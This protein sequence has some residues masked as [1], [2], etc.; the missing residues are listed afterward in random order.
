M[1]QV[2]FILTCLFIA[3]LM[4]RAQDEPIPLWELSRQ[5][6]AEQLGIVFSAPQDWSVYI[7]ELHYA[8]YV[9]EDYTDFR[10]L[11]DNDHSTL[12]AH[13][14]I[15][16]TASRMDSQTQS[17]SLESIARVSAEVSGV[18]IL[19]TYQSSI[20]ARPAVQIVIVGVDANHSGMMALWKQ[21][22]VVFTFALTVVGIEISDELRLSWAQ[23]L[24]SVYSNNPLELTETAEVSFLAYSINYPTGWSVRVDQRS[25]FNSLNIS[26]FSGDD[27]EQGYRIIIWT[28]RMAND[29][30][31]SRS[32]IATRLAGVFNVNAETRIPT[33]D[34][35]ILGYAGIGMG[36][37][38][39]TGETTYGILVPHTPAAELETYYIVIAP[40]QTHLNDFWATWIAMLQSVRLVE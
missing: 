33:D 17:I 39:S 26:E 15:S 16:L 8:V 28:T 25:D 4:V 31:D 35:M 36:W 29:E 24:E 20:L 5:V 22:N 2:I 34:Y 19:E 13:P 37:S 9:A 32:H 6:T 11:T 21:G 23:L 7:D 38:S 27:I 10:T 12:P 14:I 30:E 3:P 1:K 40:S 18:E